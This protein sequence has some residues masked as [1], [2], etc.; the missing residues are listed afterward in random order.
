MPLNPDSV[1]GQFFPP[2]EQTLTDRECML[3]ALSVGMAADPMR[4]DELLYVF[5][6]NLKTFPTMPVV[7]CYPGTWFTRPEH[8]ITQN[9]LVAGTQ[10]L[11]LHGLISP[12]AELVA[13]HRNI[14]IADK[15]A[16]K[17]AVI[18]TE[19]R[20]LDRN[21]GALQARLENGMF[22]RA[23]GGFGGRA[24]LSYEF[25][26]LPQRAADFQV[27]MPT[28]PNQALY[29]R[30]MGDRNPL[31][32]SPPFA[33][34]SGFAR[35]I[36]HGLCSFGIAAHALMR[37]CGETAPLRVLEAR[38]SKP[39]YPG[40]TLRFEVWREGPGRHAFRALVDARQAVVLDRGRAV[41]ADDAPF[42]FAGESRS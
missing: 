19:R 28:A 1:L 4:E 27:E 3:Y 29:Y 37:G 42:G 10:R 6:E 36:L 2:I 8:A 5:E 26:A 41:F 14:E 12:Y 20:I 22:C 13:H 9:M 25:A 15:G 17:G 24:E 11:E 33:A 38:F 7:L 30:L 16:D 35:P 31:H 21:T 34:R 39:V 18:V 32:A 23:D 40:E